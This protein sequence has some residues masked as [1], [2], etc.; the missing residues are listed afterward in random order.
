VPIKAAAERE[1]QRG[2]DQR[3]NHQRQKDVRNEHYEIDRANGSRPRKRRA[4]A[5]A[6]VVRQ[7]AGQECHRNPEG[8]QHGN[9]VRGHA[10]L[11]DQN[12]SRRQ[13]NCAV[14]LRFGLM[15]GIRFDQTEARARAPD[16]HAGGL[17]GSVAFLACYL[18]VPPPHGRPHA[19]GGTGA[20]R[21]IYFV[22]LIS[23]I[24]LALVIVPLILTTLALALR[25]RFDRHRAW[26]RWTYPLWYYVS[27]T[28]V[29]VYASFYQ[30]WPAAAP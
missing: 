30:W 29:L 13:Q 3:D 27:V 17:R 7:V 9:P 4:G 14:P 2:Q 15:A 21:T 8:R 6:E 20:I 24:L 1:R 23:H 25:S 10:L 28:G 18:T 22:M 5:R 26:A 19:V 12:E 16:C 11:F